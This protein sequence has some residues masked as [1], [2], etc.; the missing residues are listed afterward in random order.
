[1][2]YTEV[3][4]EENIV[5]YTE[6]RHTPETISSSSQYISRHLPMTLSMPKLAELNTQNLNKYMKRSEDQGRSNELRDSLV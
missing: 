3:E 1:M 5:P 6:R 4:N 2:I